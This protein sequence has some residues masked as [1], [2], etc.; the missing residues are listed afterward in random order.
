[1][2]PW[3]RCPTRSTAP[4]PRSGRIP[5]IGDGVSG[6]SRFPGPTWR[7]TWTWRTSRRA[8]T[9]GERS[10]P[11]GRTMPSAA[12]GRSSH[13]NRST[14]RSDERT[15]FFF[16]TWMT[17]VPCGLHRR[18]APTFRAYCYSAAENGFLELG[19]WAGV[20]EEI[21]AFLASDDWVDM[22][23]V[24]DGRNSSL[25][26]PCA[27]RWSL[28]SPVSPGTWRIRAARRPYDPPRHGDRR[29][30]GGRPGPRSRM[31][32]PPHRGDVEATRAV[33]EWMDRESGLIQTDRV[34]PDPG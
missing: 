1:M 5:S 24:F 23:T 25:G 21:E 6:P 10:S 8:C 13:G 31:A 26:A 32:V 28:R 15:A 11:T 22:L 29:V 17:N 27:S 14:N 12:T 4:E 9:C 18:G 20:I 7:W 3:P 2:L 30:V 33:R 34:P 19:L 16:W